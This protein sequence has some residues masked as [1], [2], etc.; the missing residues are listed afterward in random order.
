MGT[1]VWN[2][3]GVIASN[4]DM[5]QLIRKKDLKTIIGI[6]KSESLVKLEITELESLKAIKKGSTIEEVKDALYECVKIHGE[7]SKY[8]ND[9]CYIENECELSTLWSE[10]LRETRPELP[11]LNNIRIFD[12]S[13]YN[14]YDVPL[15]EACF[16]FD[17][18]SCFTQTLSD[19]GHALKRA[20][21]S[22]LL[23]EWTI[24][25]Y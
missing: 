10:I 2:E 18:D 22:C 24:V 5:I 11:S 19:E 3:S 16:I 9:D 21:G 17:S 23:T 12:S 6:C 13:R 1:D 8:G 4:D 25:S 7:P 14:G 15:G 20:I